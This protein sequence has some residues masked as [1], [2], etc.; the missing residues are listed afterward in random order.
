MTAELA[1]PCVQAPGRR[2]S[3]GYGYL[4]EAGRRVYAHRRSYEDHIGPIPAGF[5]VDHTCHN[6]DPGCP[7]GNSCLHRGCI[8][9]THLE[10]VPAALNK[11]RGKSPFAKH[12]RKTH[13]VN[14]HPLNGGNVYV[15][16]DG[17]GK[18]ACR[19][20]RREQQRAAYRRRREAS[21]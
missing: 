3:H 19:T 4:N 7:G 5:Q 20:C 8:E 17:R 13:C 16:P 21:P 11:S 15:R 18:R 6:A 10:A 14:G 2:T 1:K 9:P 12:A